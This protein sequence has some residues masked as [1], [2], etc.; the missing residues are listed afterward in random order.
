MNLKS[1]MPEGFDR[2]VR[3]KSVAVP[4]IKHIFTTENVQQFR[5]QYNQNLR[6]IINERRKIRKK[7]QMTL[8]NSIKEKFEEKKNQKQKYEEAQKA[9]LLIIDRAKWGVLGYL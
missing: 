1:A 9:K 3:G 7:A 4:N 5:D 6:S 2:S 8:Q